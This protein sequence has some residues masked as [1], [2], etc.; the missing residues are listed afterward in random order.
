[1]LLGIVSFLFHREGWHLADWKTTWC[2]LLFNVTR[3]IL[4]SQA[5]KWYEKFLFDAVS[6]V[7][8][9]AT[10]YYWWSPSPR[11]TDKLKCWQYWK[12]TTWFQFPVLKQTSYRLWCFHCSYFIWLKGIFMYHLHTMQLPPTPPPLRIFINNILAWPCIVK[13]ALLLSNHFEFKCQPE[14]SSSFRKGQKLKLKVD[15]SWLF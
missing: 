15:I 12:T 5:F 8:E 13:L 6:V 2:T 1:M 11:I 4:N 9:I 14:D 10:R 3:K 7:S